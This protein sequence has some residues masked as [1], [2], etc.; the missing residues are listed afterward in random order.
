MDIFKKIKLNYVII[1]TVLVAV[2][3]RFYQLGDR[4]FHHDESI[5]AWMSWNLL[6]GN[7]GGY[8]F[9]PPYHGPFLYH[10]E[11]LVFSVF[12]INELTARILVA[13]FGVLLV[14]LMLRFLPRFIGKWTTVLA[15]IFVVVSP[16]IMYYSRFNIHDLY[17]IVFTFLMTVALF[18]F[19]E[20]KKKMYLYLFAAVFAL[21]LCTKLNTYLMTIIILSFAALF[22]LVK[23]LT[24]QK[25]HIKA[26]FKANWKSLLISL[27]ILLAIV[28]LLHITT[29]A[30]YMKTEK[31]DFLKALGKTTNNFIFGNFNHWSEMHKIQRIKGPFHFYLPIIFMYEP[32]IFMGYFVSLFYWLRNKT[33]FLIYFIGL[34]AVFTIVYFLVGASPAWMNDALHMVTWQLLFAL[35]LLLITVWASVSLIIQKKSF[36]AFLLWWSTMAYLIFSYAGEKVPWLTVHI[37][38]PWIILTAVLIKDIYLNLTSKKAQAVLLT[39]VALVTGFSFYQAIILNFTPNNVDAK[40]PLIQVQNTNDLKT[41]MDYTDKIIDKN[42]K[43]TQ[44]TV[45]SSV[46]WPLVWYWRDYPVTWPANLTGNETTPVIVADYSFDNSPILSKNYIGKKFNLNNWSWWITEIDKGNYAG[47]FSFM[48]RHDKYGAPGW[49]Y[50][51]YWVRKDIANKIGW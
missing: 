3:T 45:Q 15:T 24:K 16:S 29:I 9:D 32:L 30:Y 20:T 31:L 23:V 41:I 48:A 40:E 14:L 18:A 4:M 11:A 28:V 50:F 44:I 34:T 19:A 13:T 46:S 47:M 5:H 37:V 22:A 1:A 7:N 51:T 33:K 21:G 43:E 38:F 6:T 42:S 25:I 12:G 36:L 39:V 2:F 35:G 26:F 10:L 17:I 27:S 49:V 8:H